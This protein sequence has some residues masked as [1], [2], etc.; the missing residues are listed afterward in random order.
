[1]E[2]SFRTLRYTYRLRPGRIA[3]R[4]LREEA[5]RCRWVWNKAVEVLNETGEWVKDSALTQWRA[6]HD[7]LREGSSTAQQQEL[8]NFRAKRAKGKGRKKFKSA[9]KTR[10][11][12]NYTRVGFRIK[13]RVLIVQGGIRLPV[14]WSRDLPSEP[15][16]V[17]VYEDNLGDWYASFVVRV[18]EDALPGTSESIGVDWG[19]KKIA[20]TT[21]PE[22]DLENPAYEREAAKR[23]GALQRRQSRC[24][25]MPGQVASR[26]YTELKERVARE[27]KKFARR[28]MDDARKWAKNLVG[29]HDEIAVED[30]KPTFMMRNKHLARSAQDAAIGQAKRVLLES[31]SRAGRNIVLVNP[32][33]TTMDCSKCGARAKRR[34]ELSVRTY[35]C[36]SCGLVADRDEN[37]AR[38]IRVRAGFNPADADAVSR[39]KGLARRALAESGI[40]RL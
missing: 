14:V 7:W 31:A 13:D 35:T 20:T 9:R 40:P 25:P 22:Y 23:I 26:N 34:L 18:E 33:H 15:S 27:R 24:A 37:A 4:E 5:D 6:E 10:P 29:A 36:E 2:G 28:R 19:L 8:Q 30:F 16:S 39:S 11:S 32:A 12:M 1:M 38:V 3:V 17:R 21:N